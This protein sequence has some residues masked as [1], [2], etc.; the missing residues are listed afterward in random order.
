MTSNVPWT[1]V[2][3]YV[4][5]QQILDS[6]TSHPEFW[7]GVSRVTDDVHSTAYNTAWTNSIEEKRTFVRMQAMRFVRDIIYSIKEITKEREPIYIV[8]RNSVLALLAYDDAS[9]YLFLTPEKLTMIIALSSHP[10]AI[11]MYETVRI[12]DKIKQDVA[13]YENQH[14]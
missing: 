4:Y 10:A 9:K 6:I 8:V 12:L 3:N 1:E 11:L 7:L 14:N 2:P 5:I 13:N